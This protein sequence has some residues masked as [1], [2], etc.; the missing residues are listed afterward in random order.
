MV[1]TI[2]ERAA[3]RSFH[4]TEDL[5]H[6]IGRLEAAVKDEVNRTSAEQRYIDIDTSERVASRL[7]KWAKMF[8]AAVGVPIALGATL[9]GIYLNRDISNLN[10]L[11]RT[12][13][14]SIRPS[15]EKASRDAQQATT[16]AD[17]AIRRSD[18]LE[19]NLGRLDASIQESQSRVGALDTKVEAS[20]KQ[21]Q[22]IT[23]QAANAMQSGNVG[24]ISRSYPAFGQHVVH[25]MD[26]QVFDSV[27]KR[28]EDV[29]V[30][31]LMSIRSLTPSP[32]LQEQAAAFMSQLQGHSYRVLPVGRISLFAV[33]SQSSQDLA[34][35]DENICVYVGG[36]S[37]PPCI[38][39]FRTDKVDARTEIIKDA[40]AVEP[41]G[42]DHIK[43][44]DPS[45]V[46]PLRKELLQKSGVDFVIVFD[47]H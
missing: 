6:R 29:F 9:L 4:N 45:K 31:I 1:H 44:I 13:E 19:Q 26:G 39:Y 47:V 14:G 16:A 5:Q 40:R 10:N 8:A 33:T 43:Y 35:I 17:D 3:T 30:D 46:D 18:Q 41:I 37:G 25:M 32:N 27:Q 28:P 22:Q 11:A 38:L 36:L 23:K 20:N 15:I 21:I 24:S 42:D 2:A 7:M 34:D 12:I